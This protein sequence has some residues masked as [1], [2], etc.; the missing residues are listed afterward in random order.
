MNYYICIFLAFAI[1]TL[2]LNSFLNNTK[3][4][5]TNNKNNDSAQNSIEEKKEK[6]ATVNLDS[7]I[8]LNAEDIAKYNKK[9]SD[10]NAELDNLEKQ[11]DCATK[12]NSA[13]SDAAKSK[14]AQLKN[15]KK[16]VTN[17]S[18]NF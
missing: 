16:N 10:L 5:L 9:N 3:E 4:A 13:H 12:G 7:N 8:Q 14:A 15:K 18:T 1:T 2:L 17:F 6:E 11:I